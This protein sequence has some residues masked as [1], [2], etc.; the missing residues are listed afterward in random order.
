MRCNGRSVDFGEQN[1]LRQWLGAVEH[2]KPCALPIIGGGAESQGHLA[3][4]PADGAS[5]PFTS[6]GAG[7]L[8]VMLM[9]MFMSDLLERVWFGSA[10]GGDPLDA[11]FRLTNCRCEHGVRTPPPVIGGIIY[12]AGSPTGIAWVDGRSALGDV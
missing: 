8:A 12:P 1:R 5:V 4:S 10:L 9:Q 2:R 11:A 3:L 6:S 7:R